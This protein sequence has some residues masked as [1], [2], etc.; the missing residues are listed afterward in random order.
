[1]MVSGLLHLCVFAVGIILN[2]FLLARCFCKRWSSVPSPM[3]YLIAVQGIFSVIC[4]FLNFFII[5]TTMTRF[6]SALSCSVLPT[7]I[8]VLV[9]M[10][11][12]NFTALV[13]VKHLEVVHGRKITK[14]AVVLSLLGVIACT[15]TILSP[16]LVYPIDSGVP[17]F[18]CEGCLCNE[19]L[20]PREIDTF[21]INVTSYAPWFLLLQFIIPAAI[22]V[23]RLIMILIDNVRKEVA[24]KP[25]IISHRYCYSTDAV[26]HT[27]TIVSVVFTSFAIFSK[28]NVK[29]PMESLNSLFHVMELFSV[30]VLCF[31]VYL[32]D[33]LE[34]EYEDAIGLYSGMTDDKSLLIVDA[35]NSYNGDE[36]LLKI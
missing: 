19:G 24:A 27:I 4:I 14:K 26:V 11:V 3:M 28:Q 1:M 10:A 17:I 36:T 35:E 34:L 25:L 32:F 29:D 12:F 7:L 18:V 22:L 30:V 5:L 20:L 8:V 15:T 2:L 6:G 31:P 33:L 13:I 23:N 16:A 21:L 9:S